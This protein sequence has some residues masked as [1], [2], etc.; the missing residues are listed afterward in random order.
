MCTHGHNDRL[1]SWL[2]SDLNRIDFLLLTEIGIK[3]KEI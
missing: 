2:Q 1:I 3:Q